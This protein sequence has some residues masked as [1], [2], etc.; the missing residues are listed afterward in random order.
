M[1]FQTACVFSTANVRNNE[2]NL[3]VVAGK[4][5]AGRAGIGSAGLT[6]INFV[7]DPSSIDPEGDGADLASSSGGTVLLDFGLWKFLDLLIGLEE[8]GLRGQV[9]EYNSLVASLYLKNRGESVYSDY[10]NDGNNS[11]RT[12]FSTQKLGGAFGYKIKDLNLL[13][14]ISISR[15]NLNI[16]TE[17]TGNGGAI[18]YDSSGIQMIYSAGANWQWADRF[19]LQ[20]EYSKTEYDFGVNSWNQGDL[21]ALF[22]FSW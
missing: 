10:S 21:G 15:A 2:F 20:I 11:S 14:Y 8:G 13:P 5:G 22:A 4:F 16:K 6:K 17:I 1:F 9:L 7:N 18:A 12:H 3:P 19:S